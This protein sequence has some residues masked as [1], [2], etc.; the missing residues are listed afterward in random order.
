LCIKEGNKKVL[1]HKIF[2]YLLFV[3]ILT[4]VMLEDVG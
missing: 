2:F 1:E 4:L 3:E